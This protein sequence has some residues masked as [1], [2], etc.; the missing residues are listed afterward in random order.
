MEPIQDGLIAGLW[1][2]V[3]VGPLVVII[4][5]NTL[6]KGIKHGMLTVAGIWV[7]DLLYILISYKLLSRIT[8]LERSSFF[9][10]SI[11]LFGG[12]LV[13]I[14]GLG[15]L[16]NQ[17]KE[18]DF[19]QPIQS[20]KKDALKSFLQGFSVN[21]FNPFTIT[22]WTGAVSSSIAHKGWEVMDHY[23]FLGTILIVIIITD[24]LKVNF[25]NYIKQHISTALIN[26]VN[27]I[28][29]IIIVICGIYLILKYLNL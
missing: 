22:F 13:T 28:A 27:K 20:N 19:D 10:E 25:A 2:S 4:V 9:T 21:T 29:G 8:A 12:I 15:I 11:G 26:R 7:S 17:T 5:Q 18:L 1:L 24:S 14:I 3:L 23:L 6:K 16:L